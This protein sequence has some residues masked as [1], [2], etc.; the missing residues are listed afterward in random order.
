MFVG[1]LI[2]TLKAD[3]HI[4]VAETL[5]VTSMPT[6]EWS[7]PPV[8]IDY[9]RT[10]YLTWLH[11][12]TSNYKMSRR[13]AT[14][15]VRGMANDHERRSGCWSGSMCARL[16]SSPTRD[17]STNT[18]GRQ[19]QP[20][21]EVQIYR[22]GGPGRN[23]QVL[24][25]DQQLHAQGGNVKRARKAKAVYQP[26]FCAVA[27]TGDLA[28]GHR[29]SAKNVPDVHMLHTQRTRLFTLRAAGTCRSWHTK[30]ASNL[31]SQI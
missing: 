10:Q 17:K 3:P 13:G 14:A 18:G 28:E 21:G 24:V 27:R 12:A 6:L 11:L 25:H 29:E 9:A 7:V 4:D 19:S 2:D 30:S 22:H 31:A 26:E 16:A 23:R 5:T 8:F 1:A 15:I 20:S